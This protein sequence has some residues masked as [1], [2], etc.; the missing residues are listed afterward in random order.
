MTKIKTMKLATSKPA[1]TNNYYYVFEKH[2]LGRTQYPEI[3]SQGHYVNVTPVIF[4]RNEIKKEPEFSL[5][6][7]YVKRDTLFT[8]LYLNFPESDFGPG[9]QA[10]Q[11]ICCFDMSSL[12]ETVADAKE[13]AHRD[14][15]LDAL[16]ELGSS[17]AIKIIAPDTLRS[18]YTMSSDSVRVLDQLKGGSTVSASTSFDF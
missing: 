4:T 15:I 18:N 2:D 1:S 9:Y 13:Q 5:Y 14:S 7:M 12:R 16:T 10:H 8:R 3:W 17:F 6:P 11:D